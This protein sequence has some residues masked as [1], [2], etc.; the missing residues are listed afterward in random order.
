MKRQINKINAELLVQYIKRDCMLWYK[1][2]RKGTPSLS[3]EAD[4]QGTTTGE[5]L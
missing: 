5:I 1:P 4:M 2:W 3:E